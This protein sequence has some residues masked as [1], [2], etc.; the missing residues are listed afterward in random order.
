MMDPNP[1]E[2]HTQADTSTVCQFFSSTPPTHDPEEAMMLQDISTIP[3]VAP[4][5]MDSSAMPHDVAFH[6]YP[7]QSSFKLGHWYW[8]GSVQKSHQDFKELVDIIGHQDFDPDDVWSMPWDRINLKL[9]AS[10]RDEEGGEW[11]WEDEDAGWRKTQTTIEVPFSRTT[12]QPGARPYITA[13]LY[14]RPLISVIR[15]KLSD[16]QDN[17]LFHYEPYQLQWSAPHL[18]HEV[19]IQ[20]E[21]Y[22]SPAFMDAHRELQESP[23]EAG[24]DLPHVVA[25]LMFWLDAMHLTTFGN[26]KLWPVYMYFGNELKYRHSSGFIQRFAGTYTKGK[27][28]GRECTTHCQHEL[29]QAQWKVLLDDEFLEVYEHGI[30]ILCCDGIK[31]RFYPRIFTYSADYPEK[32][33]VAT[34]WQLGG[35]PCPQCLIPTAHL[36]N[37]GMSHDRQQ[38][39][40]LARSD[41]SRSQLVAMACNLI[42][43]KNYGV[44]S[45]AVES[46]LK[47][48]SWVPTSNTLSDGLGAFGFNL[49]ATLVVDLLHKFELGMWHMLLIHLLRILFALNKELIH[50]L[51]RRFRLV[52]LFGPATIRRF[53]ANTSEMSNMAACN[54]E[55]LLQCSLPVFKGFLPNQYNKIVM[56]LLFIMAHWHGLAKLR[57]HSDL[58]LEILDRQTTELGEQFHQ[59][60]VNVCTA[61][62]TQELD[63]EV[64][65]R[66]RRQ[67]K[68]AAKQA[69]TGRANGSGKGAVARKP[70]DTPLLRQPRRKKSF[71]FQTYKF[72]ALGDYVASIRH[73]G[74]TD[75]CSTEPLTQIELR[76]TRLRRIKQRLQNRVSYAESNETA[77]NPQLHHHIGQSEKAYDELGHYLHSHARDPAMKDFLPWLKD[78]ILDCL[79]RLDS[80]TRTSGSSEKSAQP[81]QEHSS[82]LFKSNRIYHHNLIRFNYTTYDIRRA[83]DVINPKTP[84]CNIMLLQGHVYSDRLGVLESYRLSPH[85][86]TQSTTLTE[87]N[88]LE[89]E[90]IHMDITYWQHPADG[91]EGEDQEGEDH[92]G[93]EELIPFEQR[94][95]GSTETL[96]EELDEMYTGHAFDYEN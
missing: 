94:R 23:R 2:N 44:D 72:H 95:N 21:L 48:N 64:N 39:S 53:S 46:L 66:S 90:T 29:F 50:K 71:N 55:D 18:P 49:F 63:H 60:K 65:A 81:D 11:E 52:P 31:R 26:A 7:T 92:V 36:H 45:A 37:L 79:D 41:A 88:H 28:V 24:C 84:H 89:S 12:A 93:V 54:F 13:D 15:E 68:E 40:M 69:E 83:Q 8:N 9:G 43:E 61:Y 1:P 76:Q 96:I 32:V 34:I 59:F 35:C 91:E 22:T 56:D 70:K 75:S 6:P 38:H 57:M 86:V 14:H 62:S 67:A 17:E 78:H 4:A 77:R 33:L 82:I 10:I 25:A 20:G 3:A 58:T 30:V 47:P 19:N 51:D 27:G 87:D 16:A 73:L 85:S 80:G 5:E 74:T 42:Y